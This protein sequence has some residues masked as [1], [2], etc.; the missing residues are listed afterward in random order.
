M[1]SLARLDTLFGPQ[2]PGHFDFT[3]FFEHVMLWLVPASIVI[4]ATPLYLNKAVRAQRQVQPGILLWG[5]LACALALVAIQASN[6]A[7]W[8]KTEYFRS[9]VTVTASA[10]S[11]VASICTFAIVAITHTYSLQP[12]AFLSVFFSITMLFDIAMTRSYFLRGSLSAIAVLQV[13]VVVL[14][15]VLIILEEVPKRGLYRSQHMRSAVSAETASGFWNRSLFL[16][17][18]P[19]LYFGWFHTLTADNLPN[20]AD[21]LR[22]EKLFDQ[23][24]PYWAQVSKTSK[25]ALAMALFRALT[26]QLIQVLLPRLAFIGATIAQPFLLLRTVQAVSAGNVDRSTAGGLIGA[27]A[28][29]YCGLAITRALYEHW[30]YRVITS[31]R[32]ILVV[33]IYDK[34]L[35]L[36][37]EDLENSAA[38]TL[39]STD[40]EGSGQVVQL[41]Y[42][43]W[44][45][46]IQLGLGIWFLYRFIG[47]A[48]FLIVVPIFETQKRVAATSNILAQ[49]KSVKGMGLSSA[50]SAYIEGK[51]KLEINTAMRER[52]SVLWVFGFGAINYTVTPAIVIAGAYFWTRAENP[53]SVAELFTV[54]AI[55]SLCTG[56]LISL[57]RSI[58]GWAAGFASIGRIYD[59]LV[60]EELQDPRDTPKAV[61]IPVST[62]KVSSS[63]LRSPYAVQLDCVSVTSPTTGPVLKEVTLAIP[64]GS[65]CMVWGPISCGKSTFLKLL[66]G[67]VTLNSGSIAVGSK[68]IA[69][70]SQECWIP[71]CTVQQTIVGQLKFNESRY[72]EVVRACTLDVDLA[73]LPDG[74]QTQTG[75]GGCNLSGGQRQRLS[76]ARA[77]YAQEQIMVVDDVF[78]SVDPE[79]AVA[80]FG[81]LFGPGGMVRQWNCTVIMSTNRLELLDYANQVYQ[82]GKNGKVELQSDDWEAESVASDSSGHASNDEDEDDGQ[83]QAVRNEDTEP[84]QIKA[85]DDE[86]EGE[87]LRN[88]KAGDLS[89]YSY[90][91]SSAG[92]FPILGWTLLAMIAAVGEWAPVIFLRIWYGKDPSNPYYFIGYAGC[93][94]FCVIFN[95]SSSAFYFTFVYKK[96]TKEI[97]RKLLLATMGAT[98]QYLSETDSGVLLNR[99]SQ[100]I[101]LITRRLSL[102]VN[103]FMFCEYFD[104]SSHD[105]GVNLAKVTFTTLLEIAI[106]AAGSVYSMPV[107]L[108]LTVVL[109]LTQLY[110]LRTSRQLRQLELESSSAIFT[111]FTESNDGIHHIRSFH[112]QESYRQKLYAELDRSQ[113][114][115]YL[116]YCIQRWLTLSMDIMSAVASIVLIG[117]VTSLP[118]KTSN[119]AVGLAMLSLMGF[120]GTATVYIQLWTSFETALGA[121][122]RIKQ[123][124]MSTPQEKDALSGP[125]PPINWPS[126]GK[127]DFNALTATYR[128]TDGGEHKAIDNATVT[129]RAGHKMGI[130]GRTGSG[131]STV[132]SAIL[133]LVDCT[134]SISIDGHDIR[135]VPREFLRSKITTI[136]QD[137]LRL[138]A[139]LRFNL[140]PFEGE[141]PSDDDMIGI[142][143]DVQLW[144]HVHLNG[145]LD[146][147][148]SRMRFS[149][150]QKQLMFLARGILHQAKT[151]NKIVMIDEVTSSLALDTE[152][153]IQGLI[154]ECFAGCTIILVSHRME[155]FNTVDGVLKFD[156]V[157]KTSKRALWDIF[158][159]KQLFYAVDPEHKAYR[160]RAHLSEIVALLG[161]PPKDLLLGA[162]A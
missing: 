52:Y 138:K 143:Q 148:Y 20:I 33:A 93:A 150:G 26:W 40:V 73:E 68:H 48:C 41:G 156:S 114:P 64:W 106:I 35:R 81:N 2:L 60:Q 86:N 153:D 66:L 5:K 32:G 140:F 154:D 107:M 120:S 108:L 15:L 90:F 129:I 44:S 131:K 88:I 95:I 27:T 80:I 56:P 70:C 79:T 92:I 141:K 104:S 43:S 74:D 55:L 16:W 139:S 83:Q 85:K 142:L 30:E 34:L 123:F 61:D 4:L 133:R 89:L 158:E 65:L 112:W 51:R 99:F 159:G 155:S 63:P 37:S 54:I 103:Q 97:H 71:N 42:E 152:D 145:G 116:L 46:V 76:L 10:M 8:H 134:G 87:P 21:E 94:I 53:M 14:K 13:C 144:T 98:P 58:N 121:V 39:M 57:F 101:S 69:Y 22:S 115:T 157:S 67:E 105:V 11:L 36:R 147:D 19:L 50:L 3:L 132:L 23:F 160:R 31:T 109:F 100:D 119:A 117:V 29:I 126:A 113:N 45:C 24:V 49:M 149:S 12:S 111:H 136:T 1:S 137:G 110:Y 102:L 25:R 7:L 77:A 78:S 17:L 6:I 128:T 9:E 47:P 118:G 75:S 96:I 151:N 130:M 91:L 84:P 125:S 162:A 18:N 135:M 38:L 122:R 59:Y 28:L 161:P 146:A 124:V 72:R 62:E 82:F 127:I